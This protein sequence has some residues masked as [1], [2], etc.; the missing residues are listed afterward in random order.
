[1]V[2]RKIRIRDIW[3]YIQGNFRFWIFR[4]WRFLMREHVIEQVVA[5]MMSA[6]KRCLDGGACI[7]CGCHMPQLMFADKSCDKPCYPP[8]M[9]RNE[10]DV[11]KREGGDSEWNYI[12]GRFHRIIECYG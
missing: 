8:M 2:I 10:W 7:I 6:D 4:R 5:R 12:N 9:S 1:M 3:Y 11:F